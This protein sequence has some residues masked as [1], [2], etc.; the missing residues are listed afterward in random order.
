MKKQSLPAQIK[1]EKLTTYECFC[2]ACRK[3][4]LT[5]Y[6]ANCPICG[7]EPSSVNEWKD[8]NFQCGYAKLEREDSTKVQLI[9]YSEQYP[10]EFLR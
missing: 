3:P 7:A 10:K 9:G 6:A 1:A 4:Y 5:E 8:G 2:Y